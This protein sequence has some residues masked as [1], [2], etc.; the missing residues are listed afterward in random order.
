MVAEV[1][2]NSIAKDLN[3]IFDYHIPT[4]LEDKI[5]VG[6]R[7]LVPF[8]N[9]KKLEDGFVIGIKEQSAYKVKDIA[10]IEGEALSEGNIELAKLMANRYFCNLSECIKLMLPPGMRTKNQENRVKTKKAQFVY[11]KE[12]IDK[13]DF[14]IEKGNIKSEKQIQLLDFLKENDHVTVSEIETFLGISRALTKTLEKNGY[15]EIVE[16]K[17]ER[18]WIL[19]G[20]IKRDKKRKLTEEQKNAFE[21]IMNA[22]ELNEFNEFL[23]YGVTGSRKNRDLSAIN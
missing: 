2:I 11:L 5:Q 9:M 1:I 10:K 20:D 13:I 14:E 8:G 3:R 16:K 15:I 19:S 4:E 7:V 22:V 6:S 12:E 18:E 23:I 21:K 17:V